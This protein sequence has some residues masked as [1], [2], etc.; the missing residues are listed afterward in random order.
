MTEFYENMLRHEQQGEGYLELILGPMFSGKTT[1]IIQIYNNY[2]YIGKKVAVINFAEDTRY[3]D[4]MLST[5]DRKMIP[6]ILSDNI[7]DNWTNPANKHYTEINAAD[8][9]LIN[10]GQFFKGLKEIV[11]NMVEQQNKIVYICGLDGD[12]KREKFGQMLE[13]IPYCDKVSKLTSLCSQC[14]NGKKALFSSRV[15]N[16]TEQVVIGSDNY[17]P[18]CRTCYLQR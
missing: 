1:Q 5:H 14:R 13:L 15:S 17:K 12:F 11:L 4:T 6:C 3:H 2:T 8:V 10:E 16:E 7:V 18:L 9:I